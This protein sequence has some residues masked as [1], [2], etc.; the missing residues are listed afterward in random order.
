MGA[1]DVMRRVLQVALGDLDAKHVYMGGWEGETSQGGR[2]ILK[3]KDDEGM[4]GFDHLRLFNKS[5]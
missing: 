5:W 4:I 3:S 2:K 1:A